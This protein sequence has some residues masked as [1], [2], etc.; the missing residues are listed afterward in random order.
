MST[1]ASSGRLVGNEKAL[2]A[3]RRLRSRTD[4]PVHFAGN[5]SELQSAQLTTIFHIL[6]ESR[7]SSRGL[8]CLENFFE[9]G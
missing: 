5:D 6:Q 7:S 2:L 1:I 3:P 4:F 8:N 9:R